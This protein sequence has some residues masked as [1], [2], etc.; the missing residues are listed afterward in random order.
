MLIDRGGDQAGGSRAVID[1]HG[2]LDRVVCLGCAAVT[3]RRRLDDRLH[4]ANLEWQGQV[5]A[6]NPDGDVEM[7]DADLDAF[8]PVDCEACGG[9]LK[10]DVVYFGESVPRP[11]VEQSYSWVEAAS[12]L[13][14][15]G[16][17]LHVFSGRRFVLRAAAAGIPVVIVNQGPTRGDDLADVRIQAPLGVTLEAIARRAVGRPRTASVVVD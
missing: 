16:T 1:L 9:V 3:D 11:R 8:T 17:S 14:V 10:P 7:A 5:L 15:L 4:A 13:L 2:R 12:A 6:T